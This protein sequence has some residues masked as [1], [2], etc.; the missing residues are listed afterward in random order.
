M[1][2]IKNIFAIAIIAIFALACTNEDDFNSSSTSFNKKN[3]IQGKVNRP[4]PE[5]EM[6]DYSD[7]KTNEMLT[8]FDQI[9]NDESAIL[10]DMSIDEALYIME[11]YINYGVIDKANSVATESNKENKTFAFTVPIDNGNVLGSEL[12]N[13]FQDF[14]VNLLTTMRGKA[15]PLSDMYVKEISATSVTFGLDICP[16]PPGPGYVEPRYHFPEFYNVGDA[17]TVPAGVESPWTQWYS[18]DHATPWE[19]WPLNIPGEDP[20]QVVEYNVYRYSIKPLNLRYNHTSN[21]YF[22]YYTGIKNNLR[23]YPYQLEE[24]V[25]IYNVVPT[26][27]AAYY[28]NLGIQNTLI[29][30][31]LGLLP[32]AFTYANSNNYLEDRVVCDYIPHIYYE[33]VYQGNPYDAIHMYIHSITVGY[34]HSEQPQMMYLRAFDIVGIYPILGV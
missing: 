31:A 20:N 30:A 16:V 33:P 15:L 8:S 11:A 10:S 21:T 22:T 14:T 3:A 12:K 32:G 9:V 25:D 18:I 5:Y 27:P 29:P 17:I 4:Y 7:S 1:K 19:P 26:H 23:F 2:K 6:K 13:I 24:Y 34:K 28:D